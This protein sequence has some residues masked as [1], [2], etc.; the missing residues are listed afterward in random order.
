MKEVVLYEPA[1]CCSTGLCGV[2]LDPEL[3]RISTLLDNFKKKG[4]EIKRYNL[5]NFPMEFMKN[6]QVNDFINDKGVDNLPLTTL[7][8]DIVKE[9]SYPSE[10][11]FLSYLDLPEDYLK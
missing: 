7:D 10:E 11:E 6:D 2:S 3:L 9:G 5:S 4:V 1:M 8:G